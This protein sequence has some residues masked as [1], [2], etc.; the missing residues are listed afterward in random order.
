MNDCSGSEYKLDDNSY[1]ELAKDW[2]SD[3]DVGDG[4]TLKYYMYVVC[5]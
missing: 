4:K 2:I 1:V 5:E 3:K